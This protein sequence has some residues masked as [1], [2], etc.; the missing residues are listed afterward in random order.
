LFFLTQG[1][2][3][4]TR[5]ILQKNVVNRRRTI[6][7]IRRQDN[8]WADPKVAQNFVV[9]NAE[10]AVPAMILAGGLSRRMGGGDKCLLPLGGRPV[11]AHL[12]ERIRPQVAALALN[13]NGDATRFAGFGLPV[14]ADDAADFAGPL[15]GILAA[16]N[17]ARRAHPSA[18]A[19]LTVPADT[20]FLP[21]DLAA[22]LAEAGAPSVAASAGRNHPVAGLWR[23]DG[24]AAL[25]KALREEGLR[26]VEAWIAR[27]RPAVVEFAAD[28]ID[29]FFNINTPEDLARAA[30]LL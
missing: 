19:V 24:E 18:S 16:L 20:P 28:P 25:R 9:E 26:R 29:P 11:L 14:V 6:G 4:T 12:I 3:P 22:R 23:L 15:A 21:R 27:L 5:A 13:A 17:W 10:T 8:N 30:T 2:S 1:F 7:T